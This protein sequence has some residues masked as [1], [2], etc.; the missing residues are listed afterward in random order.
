MKSF[1]DKLSHLYASTEM[2][3]MQLLF[4][5]MNASTEMILTQHDLFSL[6]T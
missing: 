3:Y 5:D 4:Y 2:I 6:N 1:L